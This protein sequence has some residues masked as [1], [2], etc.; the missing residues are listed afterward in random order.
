MPNRAVL[1]FF[2]NLRRYLQ[3][4]VLL[5]LVANQKSFNYFVW[6]PLG[7]R[8]NISVNFFLQVHFRCQQSDTVLFP[9]FATGVIDN[10][11]KF[12]ARIIGTDGKFAA[13]INNTSGTSGKVS[14]LPVVPLDLSMSQ[15]IFK[16]FEMT[17]IL[18]SGAWGKIIHF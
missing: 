8:L 1:N 6:T 3:L 5:T 14:L 13:V 11:V 15:R 17:L 16:K 4:K 2:E 7:S 9:L 18:F 10:G 12:A